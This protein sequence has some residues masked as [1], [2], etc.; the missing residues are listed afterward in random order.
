MS[1]QDQ[2]EALV[3]LDLVKQAEAEASAQLGGNFAGADPEL[4]KQAQDY[5][6]IGRRLA[7]EV[8][9]DLVKEALDEEMPDSSEEEKKK[10]GKKIMAKA[11]GEKSEDDEDDEDKE[12]MDKEGMPDHPDKDSE[13][14]KKMMADPEYR[15]KYKEKMR[16]AAMGDYGHGDGH[17]DG[18]DGDKDSEEYKRKMKKKEEE[19]EH[20][21]KKAAVQAAVLRKMGEDPAYLNHLISKHYPG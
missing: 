11:R 3:G 17:D 9:T 21:E 4:I 13:E 15:K 1:M 19:S 14:Y 6:Y 7:H 2:Y 18:D 5:D 12:K 10:E 16:K 20:A 8:L